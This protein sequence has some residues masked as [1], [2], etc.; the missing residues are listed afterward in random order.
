MWTSNQER[1]RSKYESLRQVLKDH[2]DSGQRVIGEG[3]VRVDPE[4]IRRSKNYQD[5]IAKVE[6]Y[7][8]TC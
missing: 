3:T 1:K 6:E 2:P 8:Q 4:D 7:A 5:L